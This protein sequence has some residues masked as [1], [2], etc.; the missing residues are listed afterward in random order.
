MRFFVLLALL[1]AAVVGQIGFACNTTNVDFTIDYPT[2]TFVCEGDSN[3]VC[4]DDATAATA[5]WTNWVAEK[6]Y[7]GETTVA[8]DEC[9]CDFDYEWDNGLDVCVG[10][11]SWGTFS[12]LPKMRVLRAPVFFEV[13]RF[14]VL[15]RLHV[16]GMHV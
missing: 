13:C 10:M 5:A 1:P 7:S 4:I 15:L 11:Y 8:G 14:C 3:A 2:I 6:T 9:V 12:T 16:C